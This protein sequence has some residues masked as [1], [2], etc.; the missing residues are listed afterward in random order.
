MKLFYE[1][2]LLY[3]ELPST[4]QEAVDRLIRILND[5]EK[6]YIKR[7]VRYKQLNILHN[8]TLGLEIERALL[9]FHAPDETMKNALTGKKV[10]LIDATDLIIEMLRRKLPIAKL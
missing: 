8:C 5:M 7:Q 10:K 3:V 6:A 1:F 9:R 2:E 4:V